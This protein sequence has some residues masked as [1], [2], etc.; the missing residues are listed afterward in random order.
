MNRCIDHDLASLSYVAAKNKIQQK[1][2]ERN[3]KIDKNKQ[4]FLIEERF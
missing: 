1:A 3:E 4:I 2:I